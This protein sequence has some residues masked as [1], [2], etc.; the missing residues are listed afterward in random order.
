MKFYLNEVFRSI[1]G[2]GINIGE[3]SQFIR[4]AG[5][6][7][8]CPSCDTAH[9]NGTFW[10]EQKLRAFLRKNLFPVVLTGGEPMMQVGLVEAVSSFVSG[11]LTIETNGTYPV[12]YDL[13]PC[14][15]ILWSV[16]PK[17]P[18]FCPG[19]EPDL[20]VLNT[21]NTAWGALQWKFVVR[22]TWDIEAAFDMID[23]ISPT[24]G[25]IVFQPPNFRG[26]GTTR[27]AYLGLLQR[28]SQYVIRRYP[29][30][31]SETRVLPQLHILTGVK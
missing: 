3:P 17:L 6:N 30:S 24:V 20:A 29:P 11:P 18:W 12:P 13:V 31:Y 25:T 7:L 28:L 23:A 14:S 27:T 19:Y 22:N 5:C 8:A 16:S 21:F 15:N 10:E 2:E 9:W 4:A 1:Q 26:T